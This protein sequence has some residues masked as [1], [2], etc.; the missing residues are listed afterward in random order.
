MVT[1]DRNVPIAS[2]RLHPDAA[3]VP[4]PSS[5]DLRALRESLRDNGQQDALD[6]TDDGVIL[7]GR[8][9]WTVLSDLGAM[10]VRVRTADIPEQQQTNW[11]IDRALARRHLTM[12]QKQALNALMRE[13]VIEIR[14][15]AR[16][17]IARG[18]TDP[19]RVGLSQT[20]RAEK[21]GVD[22]QTV[23]NWDAGLVGEISPTS[24]LP[25]HAIDGRGRPQPL[26]KPRAA[27]PRGSTGRP[28][29][30]RKSRPIPSWS[31][32]FSTW[33]RTQSRPEDRDFL[34]RLDR[35]LHAALDRND[36]GCERE[37]K[38]S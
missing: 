3:K 27:Q 37:G 33:C 15:P 32:Y 38:A 5:A 35:E 18:N 12:A 28:T 1:T 29:P 11:I 2:L 24:E 6:V 14:E 13:Q 30:L 22:R 25:T 7:D 17:T 36:V 8:T 4:M 9:R 16:T 19:I 31:R 34:R 26:H 20:Q 23:K 21:L 10:S